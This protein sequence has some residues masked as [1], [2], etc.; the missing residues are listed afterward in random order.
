MRK[1]LISAEARP[2]GL[3]FER[4][5]DLDTTTLET[6]IVYHMSPRGMG[7]IFTLAACM[8]GPLYE[9]QLSLLGPGAPSTAVLSTLYLLYPSRLLRLSHIEILNLLCPVLG[10]SLSLLSA[11]V[12]RHHDQ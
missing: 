5:Y 6:K 2:P 11:I 8:W 7:H 3:T 10:D 1:S 9:N 12:I 4:V